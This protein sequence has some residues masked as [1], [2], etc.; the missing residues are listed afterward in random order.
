MVVCH[1]KAINADFIASLFATRKYTVTELTEQCGAGG[2]CGSCLEL[3][4]CM[5][6]RRP[7]YQP[8]RMTPMAVGIDRSQD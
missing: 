1:C 7:I 3:I 5:L 6:E 4:E 2:D 8:G